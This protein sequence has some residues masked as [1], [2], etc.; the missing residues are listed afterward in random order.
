M[1]K[2]TLDNKRYHTFNYFLKTKFNKKVFKVALDAGFTCPN[3]KTGGCI[4]CSEGSKS[5]ITDNKKTILEQ[6]KEVKNIML[7]KWPDSYYIPYL[8]ANTNTYES[9]D[10]LKEIYEP[11][12]KLDNVVGLAI[13]T[14]PDCISDEVLEYLK[15]INKRTFL[16]VE[17]GLQSSNDNTLRFIN[18]GHNVKAFDDM[19]KKLKENG[20]FVVVH[21]INGLPYETK[22]DMIN[23]IKHVNNLNLDAIK[24]H[25]LHVIK[26]TQLEK[27]YETEKFHILTKEEYIDIVCDELEYLKPEIVIERITGDPIIEN[28]ITPTWLTKKFVL[29]NDIDKEMKK[30][31]IYQGDKEKVES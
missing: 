23:T 9:V 10:K 26:N 31:N 25:M 2:Y 13:A 19:V 1:F 22:E 30:R 15:D 21:V 18:R 29:L 8:Q 17:L 12:L 6:F 24:I 16:M 27:I 14:R 20:I 4:F 5:N 3:K 7:K 11:L 28:L